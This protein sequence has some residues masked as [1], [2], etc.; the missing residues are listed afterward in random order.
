MNDDIILTTDLP[1]ASFR[2][3]KVRDL[4]D[5]GEKLLIVSTD[6]ISAFDVV[7]PNGIPFK[8]EALNRLSVF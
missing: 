3:G 4:Y 1:L 5:L 7:L 8:G 2:K 6:R